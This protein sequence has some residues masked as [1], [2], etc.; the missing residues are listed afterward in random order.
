MNQTATTPQ[1]SAIPTERSHPRSAD[2]RHKALRVLNQGG[3]RTFRLTLTLAVVFL[4]TAAVGLY[5]L[6]YGLCMAV[7]LF[8]VDHLWLD[9]AFYALLVVGGLT[10]ILPLAVSVYRL[11]CQATLAS[12]L[13]PP[14]A[15]NLPVTRKA[16]QLI[17]ILAPFTSRR[18]YSRCLA[19]GLE[20]FGWV[21]LILILPLAGSRALT[22]HLAYMAESGDWF[23]LT[24]GLLG[25]TQAAVRLVCLLFGVLMLFLSG[26]RAGFSYL[27]LIHE[28]LSLGE[29]NRYFKGFDRSFIRPFALRLSMTGWILLSIVAVLIPFVL[30]TIPWSLCMGAVYGAELTRKS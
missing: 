17:H 22:G 27:A 19:L 16:P 13:T 28:E 12:G 18:L 30:H 6:V 4:L 9:I 20:L 21:A 15:S 8:G 7:S 24:E 23:W 3:G 14:P 29:V 2:I 1:T 25:L 5:A 26:R 10:L 11:A